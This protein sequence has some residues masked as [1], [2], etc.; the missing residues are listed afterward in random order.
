MGLGTVIEHR[1]LDA[2]SQ[3]FDPAVQSFERVV[4]AAGFETERVEGST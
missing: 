4:E 3:T 2:G 1:H